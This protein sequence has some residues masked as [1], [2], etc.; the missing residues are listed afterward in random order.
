MTSLLFTVFDQYR[1]IGEWHHLRDQLKGAKDEAARK[2]EEA[3]QLLESQHR[4]THVAVLRRIG[5]LEALVEESDRTIRD[6][7]EFYRQEIFS[8]RKNCSLL[9]DENAKL[10]RKW[11]RAQNERNMSDHS[12]RRLQDQYYPLRDTFD[13]EVVKA[14]H[15]LQD[16][17][18][19][20]KQRETSLQ[21]QVDDV[22]AVKDRYWTAGCELQQEKTAGEQRHLDQASTDRQTAQNALAAK[23]AI[24]D[25]LRAQVKQ[26]SDASGIQS[27]KQQLAAASQRKQNDILQQA[28]GHVD[29]VNTEKRALVTERDQALKAKGVA[30]TQA[31]ADKAVA[32]RL[33]GQ[34]AHLDG[35]FK[36]VKDQKNQAERSLRSELATS[37]GLQND[38]TRLEAKVQQLENSLRAEQGNKSTLVKERDSFKTERDS[39]TKER[40]AIAAERDSLATKQKSL[41]AERNE[42]NRKLETA[43]NNFLEETIKACQASLA[44]QAVINGKDKEIANLRARIAQFEA[45]DDFL[46]E[47]ENACSVSSSSKQP[48]ARTQ[49]AGVGKRKKQAKPPAPKFPTNWTP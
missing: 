34:A 16:E 4:A 45:P 24:A 44:K 47:F 26:L 31:S 35:Q 32:L 10:G 42:L 27:F 18:K 7:S 46:E 37:Q 48:E 20:S 6:S 5:E 28:Q 39:L 21:K 43:N 1:A 15:S 17:L 33:Q 13:R 2:I 12:F 29:T 9:E 36:T 11:L 30:E 8:H 25:D 14:S 41:Q 40:D 38:K 49:R 19:A 3:K 23:D 22:T